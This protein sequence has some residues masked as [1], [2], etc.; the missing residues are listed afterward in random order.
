[1][2]AS[3]IPDPIKQNSNLQDLLKA[4]EEVHSNPR[5]M[6]SICNKVEVQLGKELEK[7]D[8]KLEIEVSDSGILVK[9]E[10]KL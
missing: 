10:Q 8:A 3:I 1:M 7:L 9:G 2:K 6:E 5:E 4:T